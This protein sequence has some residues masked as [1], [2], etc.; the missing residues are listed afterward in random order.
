MFDDKTERFACYFID[1]SKLRVTIG[2]FIG[3]KILNIGK[4]LV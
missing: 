1:L 4:G 2:V 3:E